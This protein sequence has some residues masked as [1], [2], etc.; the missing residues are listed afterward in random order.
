M[1]GMFEIVVVVTV[2]NAFYLEILQNIKIKKI[3]F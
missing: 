2:Q 3:L 1:M